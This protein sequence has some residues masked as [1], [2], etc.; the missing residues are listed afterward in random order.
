MSPKDEMSREN[1]ETIGQGSQRPVNGPAESEELGDSEELQNVAAPKDVLLCQ[2]VYLA[3][4]IDLQVG[5]TLQVD[6][7]L[8]SG[9]LVGMRNY[10]E[11]VTET[12]RSAGADALIP[13]FDSIREAAFSESPDLNTPPTDNDLSPNFI[14]LADA[15]FFHPG[16]SPIPGNQTVFWRGRIGEVGG[17]SIGSLSVSEATSP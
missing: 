14:H 12:L 16:G 1:D 2:L 11:G 9:R 10:L 13:I 3:N 15:Q 6:G 4:R 7:L 5:I 17:F 8:V